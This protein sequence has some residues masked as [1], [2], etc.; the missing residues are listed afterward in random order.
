MHLFILHNLAKNVGYTGSIHLLAA[1][2]SS[3][4]VILGKTDTRRIR[5]TFY[6]RKLQHYKVSLEEQVKNISMFVT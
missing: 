2:Y 6:Q 3:V 4:T 1:L 5:S